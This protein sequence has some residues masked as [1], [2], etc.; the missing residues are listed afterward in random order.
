MRQQDNNGSLFRN[1]RRQNEKQPTHNGNCII[2]GVEYRISAWVRVAGPNSRN[3]GQKFFSLS[4]TP[5]DQQRQ[6]RNGGDRRPQQE[7]PI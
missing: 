4:F 1:D 7:I 6:R 3:P 5:K 2:D